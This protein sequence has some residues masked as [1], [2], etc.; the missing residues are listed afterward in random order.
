VSPGYVVR[1]RDRRIARFDT[2]PKDTNG[3]L[4]GELRPPP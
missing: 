4:K 1:R 3:W 2:L